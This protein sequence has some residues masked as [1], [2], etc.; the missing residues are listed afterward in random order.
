MTK[1][2]KV[3]PFNQLYDLLLLTTLLLLI[4]SFF[5]HDQTFDFHIHDTY[6]VV[7]TKIF[8]WLLATLLFLAWGLYRLT[9]KILLTKYLTWLHISATLIFLIF[10][11]TMYFWHDKIFPPIEPKAISRRTLFLQDFKRER[12]VYLSFTITFIFGQITYGINFVGGLIKRV[13]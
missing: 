6:F 7:A 10:F 13:L 1:T 4:Y 8:F 12:I 5:L 11:M 3:R 9:N 2:L